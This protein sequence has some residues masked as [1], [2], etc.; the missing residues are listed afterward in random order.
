M[1]AF[2]VCHNWNYIVY[3]FID[4][5]KCFWTSL[6][7]FLAGLQNL[8]LNLTFVRCHEQ[9]AEIFSN[10]LWRHFRDTPFSRGWC[11]SWWLRWSVQGIRRSPLVGFRIRK[12]IRTIRI[13][14]PRPSPWTP[15]RPCPSADWNEKIKKMYSII[16]LSHLMCSHWDFTFF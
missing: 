9:A 16:L 10:T 8:T 12:A 1:R 15:R 3:L 11:A 5:K 7:Y 13:G 6:Q 2:G 14:T 4:G